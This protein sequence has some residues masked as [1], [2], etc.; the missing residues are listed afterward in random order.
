MQ[1]RQLHPQ[2]FRRGIGIQPQPSV[3]RRPDR[4]QHARRR[5]IRIFVRV[6]LDQP[7][8]LRLLPRHVCV[9]VVNQRTDQCILRCH[10]LNMPSASFAGK[11]FQAHRP[12]IS[13]FI[14][15]CQYGSHSV[16]ETVGIEIILFLIVFL[17]L[18]CFPTVSRLIPGISLPR[19]ARHC[20]IRATFQSPVPPPGRRTPPASTV[21]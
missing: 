16:V 12:P 5:R 14:C 2:F 11:Q 15:V 17:S 18:A 10:A 8:D 19:L 6:E 3:R 1:L 13:A 9:Q 20:G 21:S 4:R 7:L